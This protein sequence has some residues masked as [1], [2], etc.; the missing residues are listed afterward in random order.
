MNIDAAAHPDMKAFHRPFFILLNLAVG[1]NWPGKPD[2]ELFFRKR[3]VSIGSA[4]IKGDERN[5]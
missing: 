2:S 3:C 5:L 1:G 4:S